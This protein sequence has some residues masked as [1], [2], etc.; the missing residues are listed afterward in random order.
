MK[1]NSH[2]KDCK[3]Y[4][5][6]V[7]DEVMNRY[8]LDDL[9]GERY[10]LQL[11]AS[12]DACL[13]SVKIRLPEL[14]L[15]DVNMPGINGF[16]VC[17]RLKQNAES[18]SVPVIFLTAQISVEDERKGLELG[19]VDYITK[20]FSES[21]LLARIETHLSLSQTHHLL[22]KSNSV[23]QKERDYI[24]Y[25]IQSMR[26]DTRYVADDLETLISPVEESNGDLVLSSRA[27]NGHRHI[28]LADFTGHG[29][30][31]AIAG[32]LVNSLFYSQTEQGM[33][34][35]QIAE[36]INAELCC[37]LPTEIFMAAIFIDWNPKTNQVTICNRGMPPVLHY[38]QNSCIGLIGSCSFALG[39]MDVL[40][41]QCEMDQLSCITGDVLIGY[42]DGI[43]EIR[44]ESGELFGDQH[45][46]VLLAEILSTG[47]KLDSVIESLNQ[48]SAK[49]YI[50]DD[51]TLF[52]LN[53][54]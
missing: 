31:A 45:I 3:S 17:K 28:M 33:P 47:K 49:P 54:A 52:K 22:E 4:I 14:I 26:Q 16:E 53:I 8:V 5:L 7:D 41:D 29:L 27:P 15:L 48:Y 12:G 2:T 50:E 42:S 19:A 10:D 21:I 20:P 6:V 38:R 11:V 25:I 35:D 1:L 9:I 46:E 24:E 18:S 23:L 34:L 44:S 40:D 43:Q 39:I 30:T 51:A 32:P 37:K 36:I 13:E